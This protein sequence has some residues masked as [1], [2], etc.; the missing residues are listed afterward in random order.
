[1]LWMAFLS[2]IKPNGI[3]MF[4][5]AK[6]LENKPLDVHLMVENP[7]QVILNFKGAKIITFHIET[8]IDSK[9]MAIDMNK[10]YEIVS[11]IR[12]LGA[13]VGVALKP[14]TT[15]SLLRNILN[16]VDLVLIMTVEPGF[17]GQKLI[18]S[19]L[20]KIEKVREMGFERI[21]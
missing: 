19:T 13:K 8:I 6:R 5:S 18:S 9:T 15:V 17:G 14:N 7:T 1:M 3:E 11:E 21:T 20:T 4:K 12:S 10:F 2:Q 16:K